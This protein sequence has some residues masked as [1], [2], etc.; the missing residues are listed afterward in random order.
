[1][2]RLNNSQKHFA[3]K[4]QQTFR[5]FAAFLPQIS[6]ITIEKNRQTTI[7]SPFKGFERTFKGSERT[8]KG[9][10]RRFINRQKTFLS[11]DK[12][13]LSLLATSF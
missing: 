12:N 13:I 9:F 6:Y 1:M 10:E 7:K 8:F 11:V 2:E 5:Y 3:V 4:T